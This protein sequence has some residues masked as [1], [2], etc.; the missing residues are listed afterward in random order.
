[1]GIK[2]KFIRKLN[3]DKRMEQIKTDKKISYNPFNR[4]DQRSIP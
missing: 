3:T 1:M 2:I 4:L